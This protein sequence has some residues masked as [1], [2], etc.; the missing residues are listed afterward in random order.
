M[1]RPHV[2]NLRE[3]TKLVALVQSV[4]PAQRFDEDSPAAW[5]LILDDVRYEDA[6]AALKV[7]A[8]SMDFITPNAVGSA[9]K[10]VRSGRVA[11]VG[12]SAG[13]IADRVAVESDEHERA[14]AR[15]VRQA[16]AD[17]RLDAAGYRAYLER[18]VPV[19]SPPQALPAGPSRR[20]VGGGGSGLRGMPEGWADLLKR[21]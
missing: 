14:E 3:V 19:T 2:V 17:G 10:A 15:Y 13:V 7:C 9:A 6:V 21:P 1:E 18:G 11:A 5:L 4:C 20:L 12:V 8:R 16:V